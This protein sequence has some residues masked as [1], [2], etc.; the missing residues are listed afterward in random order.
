MAISQTD[1][2]TDCSVFKSDN[3]MDVVLFEITIRDTYFICLHIVVKPIR[4]RTS[5][6]KYNYEN[7]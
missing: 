4:N 3:L 7:I 5:T 6:N 2:Q 1:K